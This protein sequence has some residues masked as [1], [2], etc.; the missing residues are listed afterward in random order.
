MRQLGYLGAV[1]AVSTLPEAD[2]DAWNPELRSIPTG[3]RPLP[4]RGNEPRESSQT[5][6]ISQALREPKKCSPLQSGEGVQ[7]SETE[8]NGHQPPA[9]G[10]P[11]IKGCW[12]P[13]QDT[14]TAG[15]CSG[16]LLRPRSWSPSK[17]STQASGQEQAL[18]GGGR[19]S[20]AG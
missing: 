5:K 1:G 2:Q 8:Q 15:L 16:H 18:P 3:G 19:C 12:E 10:D 6:F 4:G 9:V 11:G 17:P 13:S 7:K 14:P 20:P